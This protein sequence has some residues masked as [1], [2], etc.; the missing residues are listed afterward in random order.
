MVFLILNALR[1]ALDY[2]MDSEVTFQNVET[3]EGSYKHQPELGP[4]W[5][6]RYTYY[7]ATV[8]FIPGEKFLEEENRVLEEKLRLI[9]ERKREE[10]EKKK[11]R[12]NYIN[13][14]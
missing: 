13:C 8:S 6:E 1:K 3:L 4:E 7:K 14:I 10:E 2:T 11:R 12:R 9:E 5:I